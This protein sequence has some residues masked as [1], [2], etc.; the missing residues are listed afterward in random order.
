MTPAIAKAL[1]VLAPPLGTNDKYTGCPEGRFETLELGFPEQV[2]SPFHKAGGL[3]PHIPTARGQGSASLGLCEIGR[4]TAIEISGGNS[5]LN[6]PT[7]AYHK[8]AKPCKYVTA[9]R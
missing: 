7:P 5:C 1:A 8:I 3:P 4:T 6:C 9:Y 2:P